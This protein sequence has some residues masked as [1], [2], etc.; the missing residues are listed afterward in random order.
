MEEKDL[1]LQ[2]TNLALGELTTN[3]LKIKEEIKNKLED[4]KAENYD[5]TTIDKAK[6]DKAMLNRTAKKLNDERIRLEKEFMKPFDEFKMVIKEITEMIKDSSSK[7]DEIVKEVENKDKEEKKKAI[8]VIFES[9]VKE[10]KDVLKF[11]K[12]F[13]ERYLNKTFKIEDVEKDLIGKLDQIRNDLITISELHSKYEIELKNDYLN[14]FDLGIVIRK[15]SELISKEEALK[16]QE[17]ETKKVIEEQKE[18]K[19]QEIVN[20][21][22]ETRVTKEPKKLLTYRLDIT[23]DED[24]QRALKKFLDTTGMTYEKVA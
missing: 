24:Q 3:A 14:N 1:E 11:E 23:G 7:I 15:N 20:R 4:Y 18:E 16:N 12:V 6:E 10:L 17:E 22:I 19:V 2:V 5:I 9:E 13:D 21:V 8:L